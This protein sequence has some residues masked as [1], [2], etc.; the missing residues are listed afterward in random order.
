MV[1]I[2]P[3]RLV[4][5]NETLNQQR[6]SGWGSAAI[7]KHILSPRVCSL[8]TVHTHLYQNNKLIL[9]LFLTLIWQLKVVAVVSIAEGVPPCEFR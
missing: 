4:N 1:S 5:V 7:S 8:W 3:S 9:I 2:C 6:P